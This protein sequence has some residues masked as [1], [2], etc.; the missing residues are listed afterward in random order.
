MKRGTSTSGRG[1]TLI[2][3]VATLAIL[4][5]LAVAAFPVADLTAKRIKEQELRYTLRQ[6]REAIDAYKRAGDDGRIQRKVG[7]SGYP[8][9]LEVL[10]AGVEDARS[11]VKAKI[12]FLRR[13][14]TDPMAEPGLAGVESWGKRS[15][16]SPPNEPKSGDDVYDVY[17]LSPL[18]GINGIAYRDW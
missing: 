3:L 4:A 16:A 13:I 5:L 17:S 9:T 18:K 12:Y 2:E 15:Y 14:P 8:P 1:F 11:P 10:A 6:M 7:D